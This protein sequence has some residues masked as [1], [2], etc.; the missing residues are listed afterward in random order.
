MASPTKRT[1]KNGKRTKND[2]SA[3]RPFKELGGGA[4]GASW[5]RVP[6]QL[7]KLGEGG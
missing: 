2:G 5:L 6:Q 1:L 3:Y 4:R 7:T